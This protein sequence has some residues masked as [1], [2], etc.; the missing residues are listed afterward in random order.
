M[1]TDACRHT[2][3]HNRRVETPR[4]VWDMGSR[5]SCIYKQ[6]AVMLAVTVCPVE[7]ITSTSGTLFHV[8]SLA[9]TAGGFAIDTKKTYLTPILFLAVFWR[10][11][12]CFF[13]FFVFRS[14]SAEH[15]TAAA[16]HTEEVSSWGTATSKQQPR[17]RPATTTRRPSWRHPKLL[18]DDDA[19]AA[20]RTTAAPVSDSRR[21]RGR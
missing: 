7:L 4:C 15:A 12:S 14:G 1:C 9:A 10:F 16:H 3:E 8:R 17:Q 6:G 19:E 20:A 2:A 18:A 11:A 5:P 13:F 21:R